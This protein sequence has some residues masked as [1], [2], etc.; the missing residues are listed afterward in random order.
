MFNERLS[1]GIAH[2]QRVAT[3][4]RTRRYTVTPW[5]QALL[6]EQ[7]RQ[8]IRDTQCKLA[9]EPDLI[10]SR[11][12]DGIIVVDAK[13]AMHSTETNRYAVSR[14]CVN[15]GIQYLA[16]W[17]VPLYYVLGNLGVLSPSEILSYGRIG[18]RSTGGAYY[19]VDGHL[20]HFFDDVFGPPE[21]P[22]LAA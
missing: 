2:E 5:G 20:A 15:F 14:R 18:P 17:G 3:E 9:H 4:L 6:P 19:L 22:A 21:P 1:T 13:T 16:T 7:T 11:P 12:G 8:V 10:A